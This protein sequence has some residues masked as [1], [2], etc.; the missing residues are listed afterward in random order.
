M[1]TF[2]RSVEYLHRTMSEDTLQ[3]IMEMLRNDTSLSGS[4]L[5]PLERN[6]RKL[7]VD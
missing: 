3:A 6:I 7:F 1:V 4:E 5:M 2:E